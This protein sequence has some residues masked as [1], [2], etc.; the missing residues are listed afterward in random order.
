MRRITDPCHEI[1][2]PTAA[3]RKTFCVLGVP[4]GGTTMIAELLERMGVFM[5]ANVAPKT[6]EDREFLGHRGHRD[7]FEDSRR[8][9]EKV[10]YLLGINHLIDR[11]NNDHDVWGWKDPIAAFYASE[12]VDRLINP[13][14]IFVTRDL[15][16]VARHEMLFEDGPY[17]PQHILAHILVASQAISR[18]CAFLA[19]QKKPALMVS[20]ERSLVAPDKMVCSLAEF[21][22]YGSAVND[23]VSFVKPARRA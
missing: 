20:Y 11:R 21:V 14:Y 10:N 6:R 7:L 23:L 15:G 4:R 1:F 18:V 2:P 9:K 3:A 19:G 5:G 16:A 13:H 17:P 8:K 22:G 12:I